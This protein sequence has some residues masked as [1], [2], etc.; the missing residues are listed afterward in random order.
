MNSKTEI[1]RKMIK[2]RKSLDQRENKQIA[3]C[4]NMA[5]STLYC[6]SIRIAYYMSI[7]GEPSL[8]TL[9]FK[10]ETVSLFPKV[11]GDELNFLTVN[12]PDG[13][14]V[15]SYGILEPA[16]GELVEIEA[17]DL[18]LVPGV[19]FDRDGYRIGY[20]KGYYDRFMAANSAVITCGV[21]FNELLMDNLPHDPWD[22]RVDYLVTEM[23]VIKTT[24]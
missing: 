6:D 12:S 4:E 18:I 21:S 15:G 3:L 7:Q 11:V 17:I 1:R 16:E 19:V 9:F 2:R 20:G 13:F 8:E 24:K 10:P 5:G 22:Q 14:S 23:G